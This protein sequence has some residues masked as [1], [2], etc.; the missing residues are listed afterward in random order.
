MLRVTSGMTQRER[1]SGLQ[2]TVKGW[3]KR[4]VDSG[5]RTKKPFG[6]GVLVRLMGPSPRPHGPPSYLKR[7]Q[8][9]LRLRLAQNAQFPTTPARCQPDVPVLRFDDPLVPI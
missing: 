1:L 9:H 7:R 2:P 3:P 8:N 4:K 5:P 6:A